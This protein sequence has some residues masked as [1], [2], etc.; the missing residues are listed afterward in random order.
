MAE[1]GGREAFGEA[2]AAVLDVVDRL[3]ED[4]MTRPGLGS[5]DVRGL[6]GHLLR[7]IRTP[8]DYL[9]MDA[10]E[11]APIP[12]VAAYF[13][14]YLEGAERDLG[15]PAAI[16]ARGDAVLAGVTALDAR[17]LFHEAVAEA[18]AVLSATP[19]DRAL[20]TAYGVMFLDDYL[21]AR[22]FEIVVHGLD[23]ARAIGTTW[24]PPDVSALDAL[25]LLSEVA[26]L[27]AVAGDLLLAL[28]GRAGITVPPIVA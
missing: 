23:L 11:S 18:V 17:R 3:S 24:R 12:G 16:A 4:L 5:W 25:A 8:I 13:I 26:V 20:P 21:R 19:G 7:G 10:P 9:A 14:R 2:A 28:T 22:N 1:N 27:R 15:V 6:A